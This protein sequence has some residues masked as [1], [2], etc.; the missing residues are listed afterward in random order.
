MLAQRWCAVTY[1]VIAVR[2]LGRILRLVHRSQRRN[3]VVLLG[4]LAPP[5][6]HV[7]AALALA[8]NHVAMV[9]QRAARIAVAQA[10]AVDALR[11]AVRLLQTLVAVLAAH[12]SL[13]RALAG[14]HVAAGVVGRA[15][16]VARAALAPLLVR[17][18]QIPEAIATGV[19]P[20]TDHVRPTVA[21]TGHDAVLRI[22][23]RIADALVQGADRVTVAGWRKHEMLC[24]LGGKRKG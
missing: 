12:V 18:A 21:R 24:V 23:D 22:G 3:E 14:V 8:A 17:F 9:V 11:Q 10:A 2:A 1:T 5:A 19:A 13:A 4:H 7:V 16:N 15:Q 20:P 6:G